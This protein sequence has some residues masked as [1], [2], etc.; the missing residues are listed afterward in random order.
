MKELLFVL[1]LLI[2]YL[3]GSLVQSTKVQTIVDSYGMYKLNNGRYVSYVKEEPLTT[4]VLYL[5][6]LD[7]LNKIEVSLRRY[8]YD[9]GD[10]TYI[11]FKD[12]GSYT[13]TLEGILGE[14][15]DTPHIIER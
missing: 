9:C 13:K 14:S 5:A 2:A 12:I 8:D 10:G 6:I 7:R 3:W 11:Q 15:A 4:E 1:L